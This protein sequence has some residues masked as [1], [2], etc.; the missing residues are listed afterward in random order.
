[1]SRYISHAFELAIP[2]AVTR[3]SWYVTLMESAPFYGGPEEGGWWGQDTRIIAFKE[4]PSEE[5]AKAAYEAVLKTAEEM[6]LL[7]RRRYGQECQESMDWLEARGLEADFLP[8]P[9]GESTYFV[10]I[11]K[12]LPR[13]HTGDRQYC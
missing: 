3:Q 5:T 2:D 7:S 6:T 9:D 12:E 10:Y 4:F 8:E 13:E 1:M 11:G